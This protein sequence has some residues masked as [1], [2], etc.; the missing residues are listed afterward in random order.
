MAP[1]FAKQQFCN[2]S[3]TEFESDVANMTWIFDKCTLSDSPTKNSTRPTI[4]GSAVGHVIAC[5]YWLIFV[6]GVPGNLLVAA[7]VVWKL[8]KS[9]F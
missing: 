9:P 8:V 2:I 7:V 1:S 6:V 5:L 3:T 4:P